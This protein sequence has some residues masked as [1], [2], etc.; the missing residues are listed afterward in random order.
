MDP[1]VEHHLFNIANNKALENEDGTLSTVKGIIVDIDGT[2]TLIPT[3][4]DGKEVDTQTAIENANKSGVNW[5]RAFGDSAVDTLREIEIENKK[6]MLDTTTPEEAQS[7]LDAYYEEL[8]SI[9][10]GERV[11][12]REVGK[13]GL[14]GLMLGGQKLGFNMGPVWESIKGQGFALGGL[15]SN[16]KGITTEEGLEM[17]KKAFVRD[18]KKADLNNDNQLSDYEKARGDAVQKAMAD[19]PEQDEKFSAAHG[20]MACGCGMSEGSCGCGKD[21]IMGYDNVSGNPIPLGSNPENVRDDIEANISMDEYVLP[22]HVVKWH[23]LK[24]IMSMQEEAEMGLMVMHTEGLI[25]HVDQEE[26]DSEGFEDAEVSYEDDTEQEEASE[27]PETQEDVPSEDIDLEIAA[28]QVDDMLDDLDDIEEVLPKT[29]KLPGML[30]KQKYAFTIQHGY[31]L[32][33]P[34]RGTYGTETEIHTRS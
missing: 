28:V 12:V 7:K 3:I 9:P 23:G 14:M 20:G 33:G 1:L 19:D 26:P 16:T 21:G 15:A 31:P 4:W 10:V 25:H 27:T 32:V 34:I 17:A 6:Q 5:Q 29:S 24:H 30:K 22:A 8:D 18:D 2:Q 13:L 11:G